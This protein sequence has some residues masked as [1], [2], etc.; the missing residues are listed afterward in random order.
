MQC[1]EDPN[2]EKNANNFWYE[3]FP[4]YCSDHH[5][6]SLMK[7][8]CSDIDTNSIPLMA[9]LNSK[10][11]DNTSIEILYCKWSLSFGDKLKDLNINF[12]I[13]E[14]K[15]SNYYMIITY[16]NQTVTK[17]NLFRSLN[18]EMN[19]V[20]AIEF[21]FYSSNHNFED[22]FSFLLSD[23]KN[24]FTST[25]FIVCCSCL[26]V[27]VLLFILIGIIAIVYKRKISFQRLQVTQNRFS[28]N[29]EAKSV[30]I[31]QR[32]TNILKNLLEKYSSDHYE[33]NQICP[34]CFEIFKEKVTTLLCSHMFHH[35]CIEEWCLQ[36]AVNPKCPCC[37]FEIL[38]EVKIPSKK[39]N[40][41]EEC[42]C[43]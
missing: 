27:L 16:A 4:L 5:S 31:I 39:N 9:K 10:N 32:N 8:Y 26:G 21:L 7:D 19:K 1:L 6:L 30:R 29:T 35:H 22:P 34:I 37:N 18:K 24:I 2:N 36:S 42:K 17:E 15:I 33:G 12:N 43:N 20:V 28:R 3:L 38:G 23:K 13:Y 25:E 14:E 41:F 11:K 40:Q